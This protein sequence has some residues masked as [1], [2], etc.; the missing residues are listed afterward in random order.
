LP[1]IEVAWVAHR[2]LIG[3]LLLVGVV[4]ALYLL[5]KLHPRRPAPAPA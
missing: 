3:V 4:A 1:T 5:R 2:L